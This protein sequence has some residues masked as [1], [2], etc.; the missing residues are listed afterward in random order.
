[1]VVV[2]GD[3]CRARQHRVRA[4]F[5]EYL[6][7]AVPVQIMSVTLHAATMNAATRVRK[8]AYTRQHCA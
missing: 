1:M 4:A 8:S 6:S 3:A 7:G 5:R 2:C